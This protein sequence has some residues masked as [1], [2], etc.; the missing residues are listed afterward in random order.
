MSGE[1]TWPNWYLG[2]DAAL[3]LHAQ[4]G[5]SAGVVLND[6]EM[7]ARWIANQK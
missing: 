2:L 6:A 4:S 5:A 7:F 3:R 1:V